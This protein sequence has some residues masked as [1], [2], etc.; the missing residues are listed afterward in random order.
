M[1]A[2]V[3]R[4]HVEKLIHAHLLQIANSVKPLST[5]ARNE[6]LGRNVEEIG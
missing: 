3:A 5:V 6:D 4:D 2:G 1:A